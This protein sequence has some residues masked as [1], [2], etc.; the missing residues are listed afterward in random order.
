MVTRRGGDL[1]VILALMTVLGSSAAC[2]GGSSGPA[3]LPAL[4]SSVATPLPTASASPAASPSPVASATA[5]TQR[6][7]KAELAAVTAVVRRYFATVNDL[8]RTMNANE[9]ADEFT[10]AC[11][12][13]AQV[14]AVR[15][16]AAKHEHY[17]DHATVNAL[18]PVLQDPSH[19]QVLAD[20]DS[21][22]GGLVSRDGRRI[23]TTR[24]EIHVR[25]NFELRRGNS[26]WRI[27][28]IEEIS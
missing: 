13:Q 14:R 17:I 7:R 5:A 3:T 1:G 19:A 20:Y 23:T 22:S 9:L 16:A 11:P 2:S 4:S 6:T 12:C 28:S 10:S 26:V 15:S 25:W 21:T 24:S 8:H 18:R 27:S